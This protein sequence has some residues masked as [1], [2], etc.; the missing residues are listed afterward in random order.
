MAV[1]KSAEI[2]LITTNARFSR[3]GLRHLV[4]GVIDFVAGIAA[5]VACVY[6]GQPLDTVKVKMQTFPKLYTGMKMCLAETFRQDG[7]RGLYAGSVP[8]LAANVAEN[9]VVF[10]AYGFCQKFVALMSRKERVADLHPVESAC[11]GSLAAVFATMVLC[12]TELIKCRLQSV[13]ETSGGA[14]RDIGAYSITR[15]ILCKEGFR[16]LFHGLL[17]TVAREVPG[18]F[19]FF[20][21]Y[22]LSRYLM[23][24]PGRSKEHIGE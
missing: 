14:C 23:A 19:F 5:G 2:E 15:E 10:L 6:S 13:R 22:E 12:P 4:D 16:G 18:Y 11:A 3:A 24:Q 7:V 20:G 8:A 21:S 17:P 9:S 1:E